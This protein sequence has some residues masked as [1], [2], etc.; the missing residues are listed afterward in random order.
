LDDKHREKVFDFNLSTRQSNA[1]SMPYEY[2]IEFVKTCEELPEKIK[3]IEADCWLITAVLPHL[4]AKT[5]DD[6][7]YF[8]LKR[9]I[10]I[11]IDQE[12]GKS[13]K[14]WFGK[15]SSKKEKA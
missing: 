9:R 15:I 5:E 13:I 8:I 14:N 2:E 6:P 7:K 1:T 11:T 3:A 12:I 10:T 4:E